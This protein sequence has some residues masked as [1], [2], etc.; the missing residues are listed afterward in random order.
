MLGV[1]KLITPKIP[2]GMLEKTPEANVSLK[3]LILM[4]PITCTRKFPIAIPEQIIPTQVPISRF[5]AIIK[6]ERM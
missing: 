5:N 1:I 4:Y 3:F 2:N 6:Y